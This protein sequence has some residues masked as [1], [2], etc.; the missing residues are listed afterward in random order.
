ME[1]TRLGGFKKNESTEL[2]VQGSKMA[3]IELKKEGMTKA[4]CMEFSKNF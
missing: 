2:G 3:L 4:H 1:K